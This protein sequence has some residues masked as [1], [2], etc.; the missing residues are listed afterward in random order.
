MSIKRAEIYK[1]IEQNFNIKPD[2]PFSSTPQ[3]AIFRDK[4][5]KKWF[6]LLMDLSGDKLGLK[7]R[8]KL[9][10]NL[11]CDPNLVTILKDNVQILPAYHMNKKHWISIN[12]SSNIDESLVFDLIKESFK[13]VSKGRLE[14]KLKCGS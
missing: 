3:C 4:E 13:L 8:E 12:L 5:S 2:F 7:G 10:L 9:V 11:K 14:S 6:G 1:F